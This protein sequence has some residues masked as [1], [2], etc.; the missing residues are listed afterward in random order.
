[1]TTERE[2]P[3]YQS[4]KHVW[5]LKI[6]AIETAE[7]GSAQIAPVDEGYSC[8]NTKPGFAERFKGDEDDLGY[9]VLYRGGYESWSPTGAFESGY[10]R[11]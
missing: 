4:H 7:D 5:A 1:M 3:K 11:I 10:T 6:A 9:Y 2:L 8:I